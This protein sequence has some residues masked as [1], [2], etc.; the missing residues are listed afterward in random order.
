MLQTNGLYEDTPLL[1]DTVSDCMTQNA[2]IYP[3][4]TAFIF[5]E[6]EYTWNEADKMTDNIAVSMLNKNIRKGCHIGFWSLNTVQLVFYLIAAM[7]IGAVPTVINYSYRSLELKK[8]IKKANIE[9]LFLGEYKKG[10]DYGGMAEEV[11]GECPGLKE[12][13]HMEKTSEELRRIYG[14][15]SAVAKAELSVLLTY[16]NAVETD[17]VIGITFTSGTTKDPKPV[18]LSHY[19]VLNNARQFAARMHVG[20]EENDVLLAPLPLFHSSGMTGMLCFSLVAGIPTVI[21][22]RFTANDALRA[23]E[24]YHVTVLMAVPSMLELMACSYNEEEFDIS[25]LRIG[26]TSGAGI[27][28][29]KLQR[30]IETLGF[31]HFTMAYGQTECSPLIT[32]TLY[33]DDWATITGT[34]GKPLSYVKVRIWDLEKDCE[35]PA[36]KTGEIQVQGF[37]TMKG[38]Y[39]CEEE[40]RKKYTADGWLKTT[41]T[42]YFDERGYLHFVTRISDIII[43]HGENISPMEIEGVIEQYSDDI[44]KVKVV[45][46]A[47]EVVQEEV[48]CVIQCSL[49]RID[50]EDVK[51]Y[52]KKILASYKVPK[53]VI[54]VDAFPMT[55][56]GKIDLAAVKRIAQEF[57]ADE[58]I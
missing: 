37:N 1:R 8:I 18:M 39:H 43:R 20:H 40:N 50:P 19:N 34:V 45:G 38:Y 32:T 51:S 47:E 24:R 57:A 10:S 21:L 53:Y 36:G 13:C 49:G 29:G 42:G 30:I 27:S 5:D 17:D 14:E 31:D 16:K 23:I 12:I 28:A 54:Q 3:N 48:A 9:Q 4:R 2:L 55:E 7:K 22:R 26:Q 33:E 52:V 46:V 58:K 15:R 35:L 44:I 25:S 11:R 56:T 6:I 41:D